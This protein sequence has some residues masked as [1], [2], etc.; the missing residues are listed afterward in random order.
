MLEEGNQI[1]IELCAL[2]KAHSSMK[3]RSR[4]GLQ[5]TASSRQGKPSKRD[6]KRRGAALDKALEQALAPQEV[7]H[8]MHKPSKNHQEKEP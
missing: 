7:D 8:P 2:L 6:T 5:L 4:R 1:V 3:K